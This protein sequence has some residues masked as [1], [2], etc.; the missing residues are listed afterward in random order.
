MVNFKGGALTETTLYILAALTRPLHGYGIIK[1]VEGMT[2]G[3]LVLGPGTLYGALQ[4]LEK[5]GAIKA[6]GAPE[7]GRNKKTYKIT[8]GGLVILKSELGRINELARNISQAIG[9]R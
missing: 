4:A 8:G 1:K 5:S 9:G 2:G 3:R 6:V 7:G